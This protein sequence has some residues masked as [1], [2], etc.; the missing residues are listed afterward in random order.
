[1]IIIFLIDT[2]QGDSGGPLMMFNSDNFWEVVGITSYG[3]GCAEPDY[4]GVYTRVAAYEMWIN[5]TMNNGNHLYFT[6]YTILISLI[7][8]YVK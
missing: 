5:I 8:F 3:H 6:I 2:C 7:L 4:P 1:M